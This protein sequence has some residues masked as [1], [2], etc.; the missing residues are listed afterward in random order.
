MVTDLQAKVAAQQTIMKDLQATVAAQQA[1]LAEQ[2][3]APESTTAEHH[4]VTHVLNLLHV[5]PLSLVSALLLRSWRPS[6]RTSRQRS[7]RSRPV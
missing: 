2:H 4:Q 7:R 5:R 6:R 1:Q 3:P